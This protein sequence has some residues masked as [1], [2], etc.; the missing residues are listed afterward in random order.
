MRFRLFIIQMKVQCTG[1]CHDTF[2]WKMTK[3]YFV[4]QQNCFERLKPQAAC[5][6]LWSIFWSHDVSITCPNQS[7]QVKLSYVCRNFPP[8][9][10][11]TLIH[12]SIVRHW[13]VFYHVSAA[14]RRGNVT[15]AEKQVC[16]PR[17]P[18]RY[19][20]ETATKIDKTNTINSF[21]FY[22]P[23]SFPLC[24]FLVFVF[25]TWP[26]KQNSGAS[27]SLPSCINAQSIFVEKFYMQAAEQSPALSCTFFL[28]PLFFCH[29]PSSLHSLLYCF[30]FSHSLMPLYEWY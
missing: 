18:H 13:R 20:M 4:F 24:L 15:P 21:F 17:G 3:W 25:L 1:D 19:E 26:L 14:R 29:P 2:P 28:S 9:R 11:S 23:L 8:P 30:H 5:D 12:D 22:S 16:V 7:I 10:R 27:P 6:W